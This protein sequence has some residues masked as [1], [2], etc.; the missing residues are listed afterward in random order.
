M[1]RAALVIGGNNYLA[2]RARD[3]GAPWVEVVPTVIDL[4]RYSSPIH[5]TQTNVE[6]IPNQFDLPR[7]VW[8]GSP[9]TVHYLQLLREPLQ[10]LAT[11][12]RFVLRVIGGGVVDIPGVQ[13][14]VMP[15]VET[16]EVKDISECQVGVMPLLDSAWEHGKCGYKLIQYMA[17]GLPLVASNVGVNSEIV[18]HGE[19]GYLA[20]TTDEWVS[21]LY[22]LLQ[23]QSLRR[24]MGVSGRD[25]V[26]KKYCIQKTG[27]QVAKLLALV[28]TRG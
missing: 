8:I 27:P 9:T 6:K 1:A 7:I 5:A 2:Q 17:C 10:H 26:E 12:Q 15:W 22:Q 14:E 16:S 21:S 3:A 23:S 11:K 24:R 18:R 20:S 28:A 13:V 4:Q 25:L 19:N